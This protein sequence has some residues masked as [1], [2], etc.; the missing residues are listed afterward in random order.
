MS[1]CF[2]MSF[3]LECI[4]SNNYMRGS[5]ATVHGASHTF[6][7]S[8]IRMV[9]ITANGMKLETTFRHLI[10]SNNINWEHERNRHIFGNIIF[11]SW[12]LPIFP[13]LGNGD[14]LPF[15]LPWIWYYRTHINGIFSWPCCCCLA[16]IIT[17]DN[18]RRNVFSINPNP[19]FVEIHSNH[20]KMPDFYFRSCL[21]LS[22]CLFLL[23]S[24]LTL[25]LFPFFHMLFVVFL[26]L[27]WQFSRDLL[28]LPSHPHLAWKSGVF[29]VIA[30]IIVDFSLL[31]VIRRKTQ[32][33]CLD[34]AP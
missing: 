3:P 11:S 8:Q 12:L 20:R 17:S 32:L 1:Y 18:Q 7:D 29:F 25:S 26:R 6:R 16:K 9:H 34:F 2:G 10:M 24:S 5:S 27:D 22:F 15:Y 33:W 19:N 14:T 21:F 13:R 31:C 4:Q 23:L 28:P 30:I